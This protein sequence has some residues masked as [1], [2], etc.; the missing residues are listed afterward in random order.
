MSGRTLYEWRIISPDGQPVAASNGIEVVPHKAMSEIERERILV[1]VT[2]IDVQRYEDE[3][4]LGFLR[5]TARPGGT[6]G[7]LDRKRVG[8]GNRVSLRVDI[9]CRGG[10]KKKNKK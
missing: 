1:V 3:R 9:G 10:I 4:I 8:S 7:A 6:K 2:G 5:R